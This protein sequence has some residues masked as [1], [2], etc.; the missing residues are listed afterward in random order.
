MEE[1]RAQQDWWQFLAVE[2]KQHIWNH[3]DVQDIIM[4]TLLCSNWRNPLLA[5]QHQP[6]AH[7]FQRYSPQTNFRAHLFADVWG[8]L[9]E[10]KMAR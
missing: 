9:N 4:P 1:A 10:E 5:D 2:I 6:W 3:L 8:V 7:I